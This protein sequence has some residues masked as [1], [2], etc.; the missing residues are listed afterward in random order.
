MKEPIESLCYLFIEMAIS[1]GQM[2]TLSFQSNKP[3]SYFNSY[4]YY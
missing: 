1:D 3:Y 4:L 2:N